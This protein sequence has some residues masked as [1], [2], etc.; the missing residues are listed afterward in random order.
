MFD[1]LPPGEPD[2]P[3]GS[4]G[5]GESGFGQFGNLG[6]LRA[7]ARN[8]AGTDLTSCAGD[9][10]IEAFAGLE[11]AG[12]A[13]DAA[14]AHVAAE[15][16]RRGVT[17]QVD[18]LRTPAALGWR[19]GLPRPDTGALVAAGTFLDRHPVI[20][21]ALVDGAVS[22]AHVRLLARLHTPRTA[23]TIELI[24]EQLVTLARGVRFET[25]ARDVRSLLAHA[26]AD[27]TEPPAPGDNHLAL[28]PTGDGA[29]VLHGELVGE[30][31]VEFRAAL[32]AEADRLFHRLASDATTTGEPLLLRRPQLLA[33]ALVELTRSGRA[34]TS[35]A[36]PAPA[37]V[38]IVLTTPA[39]LPAHLEG[40]VADET[41]AGWLTRL[42]AH[43]LDRTRLHHS[44]AALLTCD[45]RHRILVEAFTGETLALGRSRRLATPA[46][47]HAA[48]VRYGGCCFP[49]CDAPP[50][51]CELHHSPTWESGGT[52]DLDHLAPLCRHHHSTIHRTG[53]NI[54]PHS[55]WG[56]AVTTPAGRTLPAQQAGRPP[57]RPPDP[58]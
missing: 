23:A 9:D 24:Q 8:A 40:P 17:E 55:H 18:G 43:T 27:G 12:R 35:T 15:L 31:A 14:R 51:W 2:G 54:E 41:G 38:T 21:R 37:D 29:V 28:T 30:W 1:V 13:L 48:A 39:E 32:D 3:G 46:Q 49:G 20:D 6:E 50:N 34:A 19:H 33:L 56:F 45:A 7:L 25:W 5:S 16:H 36:G 26:D 10:L 22:F 47:R 53:W 57:D 4:G 58:A 42:T 52:T 44:T 11:A